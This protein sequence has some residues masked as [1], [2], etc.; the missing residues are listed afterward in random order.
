[1]SGRRLVVL[2]ALTAIGAA[3]YGLTGALIGYVTGLVASSLLPER[4]CEVPPRRTEE[5]VAPPDPE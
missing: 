3:V 2:I 1:M 4:S 5:G